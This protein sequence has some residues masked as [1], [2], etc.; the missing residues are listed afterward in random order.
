MS[1]ADLLADRRGVRNVADLPPLTARQVLKW[2]DAFHARTG[3]WP[4]EGARP[5]EIPGSGGETWYRLIVAMRN[6]TRGFPPGGSLAQLLADRRGVRNV[7]A[8][9]PLTVNQILRWADAFHAKTGEWPT[10]GCS[11]QK[12]PVA[13]GETWIN[14]DQ[15][16]KKGLRGLRG[17]S[18]LAVILSEYRG[19]RNSNLLPP[20]ALGQVLRWADEFRAKTGGWPTVRCLPQLI[21]STDGERWR[22]IDNALR[23]GLRG[24]PGGWSIAKLLARHRGTLRTKAPTSKRG[25]S[26]K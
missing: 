2:A 26:R 23:Y 1:L 14:V 5:Q 10:R 4:T 7:Q 22:N 11:P 12:I 25:A 21:E 20:L 9:P 6:G 19:V 17:E 3:R 15:A 18:S 24:L 13:G 8:L 16:L